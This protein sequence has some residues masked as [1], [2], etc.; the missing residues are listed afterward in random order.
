MSGNA[1]GPWIEPTA[2]QMPCGYYVCQNK[3]KPVPYVGAYTPGR[4]W[5]ECPGMYRINPPHLC[6]RL[7]PIEKGAK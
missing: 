5:C 4:G 6:A 2:A 1:A 3:D 7:A